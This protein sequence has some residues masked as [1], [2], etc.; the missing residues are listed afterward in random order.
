MLAIFLAVFSMLFVAY[1][2]DISYRFFNSY[3]TEIP[4]FILMGFFLLIFSSVVV[5]SM[6]G[7]FKY[8]KSG[9][10]RKRLMA[11]G[12]GAQAKV[13]S[14]D[15][16]SDGTVTTINEQPLVTIEL[17]VQDDNNKIYRVKI[18]TLISRLEIPKLQPGNIIEIKI[19]PK[20]KN[21]IIIV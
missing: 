4:S 15:E 17:E 16:A 5:F 12:K 14:I 19:D 20:D 8:F 10:E 6:G 2:E 3:D 21:K 1:E 7:A 13:I 9:R 11:Y 18:E